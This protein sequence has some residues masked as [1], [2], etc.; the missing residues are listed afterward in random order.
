M[1]FGVNRKCCGFLLEPNHSPRLTFSYPSTLESNI[2]LHFASLAPIKLIAFRDAH[3]TAGQRRSDSIQGRRCKRCKR[4]LAGLRAN[5]A[6]EVS[7]PWQAQT[8]A[9]RRTGSIHSRIPM[10]DTSFW[11]GQARRR[12]LVARLLCVFGLFHLFERNPNVR[13]LLYAA[14]TDD[15]KSI[16]AELI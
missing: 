10:I 3:S 1:V 5:A 15:E 14:R 7:M 11:V 4:L 2:L 8:G 6:V 13:G 9:R 16:K 12:D